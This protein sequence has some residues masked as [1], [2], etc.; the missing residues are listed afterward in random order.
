MIYRIQLQKLSQKLSP[1]CDNNAQS[2]SF[3]CSTKCCQTCPVIKHSLQQNCSS[4]K[5]SSLKALYKPHWQTPRA[6]PCK[7]SE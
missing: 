4:F 1:L 3:L 7:G 5:G 2:H 6:T